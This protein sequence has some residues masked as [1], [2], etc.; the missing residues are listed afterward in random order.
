MNN[1]NAKLMYEGT[2]LV[3]KIGDKVEISNGI[4]IVER[5]DK[6]WKPSSTGRVGVRYEDTESYREYFPNVIDA[7][8]YDRDDGGAGKFTKPKYTFP[9]VGAKLNNGAYVI[10]VKKASDHPGDAHLCFVLCQFG[11]QYVTWGHNMEDGGC[12]L[13]HYYTD[14]VKD[15]VDFGN[16]S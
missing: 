11:E 12:F 13:G 9:K 6:P 14:E 3:V 4:A 2:D 16:R 7:E 10:R 1:E 8:W 5:I 15:D